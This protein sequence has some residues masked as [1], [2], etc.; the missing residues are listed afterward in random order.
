MPFCEQRCHYCSF[1]TAPRDDEGLVRYLD[2]VNREVRLLAALPWAGAV[3][4]G[5]VFLGGGTP[6]LLAPDDLAHLLHGLR[7]GLALAPGAEVTVECNPESVTR[8]KL[9]R[10]RAAGV[11]RLSLGVQSLDDVLLER[12]GR[13]HDGRRAREA[14]VAAREAGFDN[15]SVDLMYGLPDQD[16]A[17]WSR[18]VDAVLAWSP[19]HVSA[20]GLTL[21]GGS[22]WG[23]GGVA[24]LP[25]EDTVVEQYWALTRAAAARGLEHY[26]IS[27]YARP[28]FHARHNEIYWQAGEYLA[29]GPGGCGHVGGVRYGTARSLPRYCAALEGG[30]LS[31]DSAERLTPRQRLGERLMLGLRTADGVPAAWFRERLDADPALTRRVDAWREHGLLVTREDRVALSEAGFLLSDALF[32]ELL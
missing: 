25:A 11:N 6:S 2:A 17:I 1:N 28:G 8:A 9:E 31:I 21:D 27:N 29:A 24:G 26:E 32:V 15:V 10:Y 7:A 3:T 12:L 13:L 20:Y 4:I 14:Y 18:T 30:A 23:A 19:D 22:A 16:V 5:T